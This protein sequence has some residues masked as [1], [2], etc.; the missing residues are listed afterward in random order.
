[1]RRPQNSKKSPTDLDKTVGDFF[2]FL[3]PFQKIFQNLGGGDC[4]PAPLVPMALVLD[5]SKAKFQVYSCPLS[6]PGGGP[7]GGG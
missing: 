1:M 5:K 3:W 4:P 7:K 2:K 6:A